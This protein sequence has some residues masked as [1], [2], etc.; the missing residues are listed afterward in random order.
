MLRQSVGVFGVPRPGEMIARDIQA[1]NI[2]NE[3]VCF[4]KAFGYFCAH[5]EWRPRREDDIVNE[6]DSGEVALTTGIGHFIAV[7]IGDVSACI[8]VFGK[9]FA[10]SGRCGVLVPD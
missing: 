10:I 7:G 1:R 6:L 4:V 9:S 8:G 2:A 3:M 5:I